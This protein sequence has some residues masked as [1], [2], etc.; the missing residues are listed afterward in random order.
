MINNKDY[1][2][3]LSAEFSGPEALLEA[4]KKAKDAGYEKIKAYSPYEIHGLSDVLG[5]DSSLLSWLVLLGLLGGIA[6]AFAMQY[7]T[8]VI[9]YPLNL[10][11][12]PLFVWPNFLP[13][14]FEAGILGGAL[15]AVI[16]MFVRNGLPAPY[17]PIF[18][19]EVTGAV[20]TTSFVMVIE[21]TD[22]QFDMQDTR[23]FLTSLNPVTVS[24]VDG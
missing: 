23:Q 21:V 16:Y 11:G 24:E 3:G 17:H 2:F 13:I 5:D 7:W 12:R 19:A 15:A 14:M 18:N 9:H 22:D 1:L 10:G 4:A 6:G 20:S 8:S